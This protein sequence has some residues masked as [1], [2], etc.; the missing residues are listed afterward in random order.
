VLEVE[1][2]TAD[3]RKEI[4]GKLAEAKQDLAKELAD[5]QL[6]ATKTSEKE[7]DAA[8][9]KREKNVK[10]FLRLA[11]QMASKV[12]SL[13]SAIYDGQ[14]QKIEEEQKQAEKAHDA[15]IERIEQLEETGAITK[16]E[17]EA[18]KMAAEQRS[19]EK[20]EELEKKKSELKHKQA[21]WDKASSV[22][23]ATIATSVA[24]VEA[25]K[26][27]P[28]I[29]PI[30]AAI[31]GAM[32]AIEIAAIIATPIPAYAKGTK[33]KDGHPGGLAIVGDAGKK[34]AVLYNNKMWITP[35]TPTLIDMPKGAV[36]YPDADR[37]PEPVFMTVMPKGEQD[38]KPI[39][40]VKNDSKKIE[41]GIAQTNSLIKQSIIMQRRLANN[42]AFESYKARRL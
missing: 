4:A 25:L 36:V 37:I 12:N 39:V 23:E 2:L 29:G 35:D 27:G 7:E 8:A 26:A 16:E 21:V 33:D 31:I 11:S 41:K 19:E 24:I 9:K 10:Q 30:M 42:A 28:F 38:S 6:K 40:I 18:R 14:I 3:K 22:V 15:E 32:G 5:I 20:N 13:V 17:A 34:E 1:E